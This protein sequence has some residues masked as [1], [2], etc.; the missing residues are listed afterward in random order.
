[1]AS[2]NE[3]HLNNAKMQFYSCESKRVSCQAIS[4]RSSEGCANDMRDPKGQRQRSFY[5]ASKQLIARV[6]SWACV[7]NM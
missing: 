6:K 4:T 2:L 1:M 5:K 3:S 7:L